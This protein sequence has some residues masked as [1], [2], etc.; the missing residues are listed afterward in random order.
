MHEW[1]AESLKTTLHVVA[2]SDTNLRKTL[3]G[4]YIKGNTRG[5]PV[6]R[7]C[8]KCSAIVHKKDIETSN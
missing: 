2:P 3:C 7:H 5:T 1:E 8:A 4:I 6:Q